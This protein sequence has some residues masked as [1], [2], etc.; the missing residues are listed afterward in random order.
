MARKRR[1]LRLL[2]KVLAVLAVA[3]I[4]LAAAGKF[5]IVPAVVRWQ[6]REKLPDYWRGSAE[7]GEIE[8]NYTGPIYLAGIRL[9][10]E[11]GRQWLSVGS[12][13]LTL[14]NWPGIEPVLSEVEID[15]LDVTAYF[16][17]RRCSP[18]LKPLPSKPTDMSRYVDIESLVVRNISLQ[19]VDEAGPGD[20]TGNV[21]FTLRRDGGDYVIRLDR[22]GRPGE[23]GFV[24]AG[25]ARK[26]D[27]RTVVL[28]RWNCRTDH[29]QILRDFAISI[30]TDPHPAGPKVRLRRIRGELCKGRLAGWFTAA[31]Q[32]TSTYAVKGALAVTDI[33]MPAVNNA[34][35]GS[36]WPPA[37]TMR[38]RLE[39][40]CLYTQMDDLRGRGTL[41]LDDADFRQHRLAGAVWDLLGVRNVNIAGPSDVEAAFH[42]TGPT[43]VIDKAHV[44][45]RLTAIDVEPGGT[46]NLATKH[47]DLYVVGAVFNELPVQLLSPLPSPFGGL[48]T[49][50]T[51]KL[52]RLHLRGK[53]DDPPTKLIAQEPLKDIADGTLEFLRDAIRGGGQLTPGVLELLNG[54]L[55][56]PAAKES[57]D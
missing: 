37:G 3:S 56:P 41:F 12:V 36:R 38:M 32:G 52:A 46:V 14:K 57:N 27:E 51:H 6:V 9:L 26:K 1:W 42:F 35:P 55:K 50:L 23:T 44:T 18:P 17:D 53:W 31:A 4:V 20:R 7:I 47:I 39:I 40:D 29:G 30:S 8:F 10:D 34:L 13:K 22:Q 11:A 48:L 49:H 24:L 43:V 28:E 45:N 19:K 21:V 33:D 2:F 16:K 15:G 54:V 25:L 5:W